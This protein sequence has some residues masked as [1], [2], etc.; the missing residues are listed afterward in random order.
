MLS[1]GL[2]I[3]G[4]LL[5]VEFYRGTRLPRPVWRPFLTA[6][7]PGVSPWNAS[8]IAIGIIKT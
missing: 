1:G 7:Y 8:T 6:L 5:V 4:F 2:Q 3:D